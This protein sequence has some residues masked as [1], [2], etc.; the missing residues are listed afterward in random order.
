[1]LCKWDYFQP[2]NDRVGY[3]EKIRLVLVIAY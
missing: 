3:K 2:Y 1:M